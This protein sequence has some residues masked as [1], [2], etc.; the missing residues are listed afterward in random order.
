M[1]CYNDTD[2]KLFVDDEEIKSPFLPIS[3]D[4][5]EIAKVIDFF[6]ESKNFREDLL[7]QQT[8]FSKKI[9]DMKKL[10][11]WWDS[12]FDEMIEKHKNIH[13]SSSKTNIKFELFLFLLGNKLYF[14]KILKF[15]KKEN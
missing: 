7:K 12:F 10:A 4:P 1:I 8:E 14:K 9:S 11:N 15:F 6:V 2:V 3:N 5:Q 13:R